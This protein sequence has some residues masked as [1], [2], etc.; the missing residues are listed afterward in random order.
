V[1]GANHTLSFD[2]FLDKVVSGAEALAAG[3]VPATRV[4]LNV[5]WRPQADICQ[6]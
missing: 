1:F 5:H 6:A 3:R 4:P 2:E